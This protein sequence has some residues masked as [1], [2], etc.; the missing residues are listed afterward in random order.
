[1]LEKPLDTLSS[2]KKHF[3]QVV[4]D[5]FGE[6]I[7]KE[8]FDKMADTL[9]QMQTADNAAKLREAEMTAL[10]LRLRTLL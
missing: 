10:T 8:V 7:S 1:M 6:S 4:R 3:S 2:G 5:S 9:H